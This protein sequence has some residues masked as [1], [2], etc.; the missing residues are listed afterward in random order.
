V[1]DH[2]SIDKIEA[3]LIELGYNIKSIDAL[4]A[5]NHWYTK[6][7]VGLYLV[8]EG[9]EP[10]SDNNIKNIAFH[11]QSEECET[12][13]ELHLLKSGRFTYKIASNI[14]ITGRWSI[15]EYPYILLE[16]DDPYLSFYYEIKKSQ[17][18]DKI[19]KIEVIELHPVNNA[20]IITNCKLIYGVRK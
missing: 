9:Y 6:N 14:I 7:T 1:K 16:N 2:S 11:Y 13:T 10:N 3:T 18:V 12:T 5:S 17:R 19:S 20:Q 4:V 8:P 15:T